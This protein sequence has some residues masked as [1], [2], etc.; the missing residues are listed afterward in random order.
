MSPKGPSVGHCWNYHYLFESSVE[1]MCYEGHYLLSNA[2][3]IVIN[4][5]MVLEFEL[6]PLANG[7]ETF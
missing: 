6:D 4:L 3:F 2:L 7:G 1:Y 5:I